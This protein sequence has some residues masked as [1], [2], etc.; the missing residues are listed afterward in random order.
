MEAREKGGPISLRPARAWPREGMEFDVQVYDPVA[1]NL[2]LSAL[3]AV[4]PIAV[5]F[6]LLAVFSV[7]AQWPSLAALGV[8][9]VVAVAAYGMPVGLAVNSAIYGAAFG[10]FPIAWIVV[11]AIFV[12]NVILEAGYFET[13][14]NSMATL[15]SDRRIQVL[16]IAFVF[17]ALLEAVA[18]F[19]T[20]VAITASLMVGLGF[21]A[22]AAASLA[23]LANT[24]LVAFG[25]FG[26]P[27]LPWARWRTSTPC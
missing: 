7:S 23:L 19:G 11:N 6:M 20:P 3:V 8:A 15:S 14:R 2:A 18:G 5:L 17:G 26:I 13:V 1:N 9:F 10:L 16:I 22:Y 12:Y 4:I 25:A 21:E 24:A 27:S